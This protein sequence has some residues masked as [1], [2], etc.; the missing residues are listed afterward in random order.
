MAP[1]QNGRLD[2]EYKL[3]SSRAAAGAALALL[4]FAG[5]PSISQA[6]QLPASN[7]EA[8]ANPARPE[9]DTKDDADR[10][11]AETI[12]FAGIKP[13]LKIG[14]LL[15]GAGYYT[16]ILSGAVGPNGHVYAI[17]SADR[18]KDHP[19]AVNAPNAIA[20]TPA[21]ANV[22]VLV[23]LL[24][25][26]EVPEKLDLVWTSRNYHDLHNPPYTA[27]LAGQLDKAVFSV[28]KPGGVYLILDH[29][30][31]KGSGLRDTETLHRIDPAAVKAEVEAAGF[32]FKGESKTLKNNN[33]S[34]KE[35]VFDAGVKGR[36]DQFIFKFVKPASATKN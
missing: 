18:V 34:H 16:R 23:R 21:F 4:L 31:E 36:T 7:S 11:P 3:F 26:L 33:D 1:S 9:A 29:A 35:K 30:A 32:V 20:A 5:L 17:V 12:T 2:F 14:E 15:P 19:E 27:E 22:S 13:G 10:K 8:V 25:T 6:A 28:L 24:G